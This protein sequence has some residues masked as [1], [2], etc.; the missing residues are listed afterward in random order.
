MRYAILHCRNSL[1][2]RHVWVPKNK[3]G[4]RGRCPLCGKAMTTPTH[5]PEDS[6]VEGPP[7]ME[8]FGGSESELDLEK[9]RV[10][11]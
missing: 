10:G 2:S 1:C 7:I 6:L 9:T 11:V 4:Q 8:G 5:I 3:L